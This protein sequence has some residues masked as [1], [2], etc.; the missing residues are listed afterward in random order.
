VHI[1]YDTN[2]KP[3]TNLKPAS[4]FAEF[5][6]KSEGKI[7]EGNLQL[8][9]VLLVTSLHKNLISISQLIS[10]DQYK[11][12]IFEDSGSRIMTKDNKK[13]QIVPRWAS[14]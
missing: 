11:R 2:E 12:I 6:N 10:D 4:G 1:A 3:F 14:F 5:G 8:S 13:N 7:V 9:N